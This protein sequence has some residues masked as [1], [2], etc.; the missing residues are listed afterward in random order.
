MTNAEAAGKLSLLAD[1]LEIQGEPFYKVAAY[2]R[3]ADAVTGLSESLAAVRERGGLTQIPGVGPAI[4]KKLESL[5]DTGT[6]DLLEKVTQRVPPTLAELLTVP[7]IGPKR[8]RLL[9]EELGI[10]SLDALRAAVESGRLTTVSGIGPKGA[11]RIAESLALVQVEE[12]R[13]QLGRAW[14]A[15]GELIDALTAA[16]P[17]L[18][19][20]ALAGSARRARETVGDLDLVAAHPEPRRVVDAFGAM[21][22]VR[23]V[24]MK[25]EN[26]CRVLQHNGLAADLRVLPPEHWGSLLHHFTGSKYH[27]VKLRDV[28]LQ[29][30]IHMNEYGFDTPNGLVPCASEEDVYRFLDMQYVPPEMREDTGEIELAMRGALPDWL[31]LEQIR[32]DFQMHTTWSDGTRTVE[33]M[34]AAARAQ[35]YDY[36]LVTDHS[37]SLGVANGLSPERLRA[38]RREI[39]AAN[40]KLAPF[41]LLQAVE[42]EVKSNGEMDLPDEVLAELDVVVAS[43]H[44]GL[45][46]GRPR[47]TERALAAIRHPLVDI[48]AHPTGRLVGG[49][50]GGDFDME[51]II[52]AAADTGTALEINADP[53]R[54]DLRDVHARAAA[55][56][57]CTIAISSDAHSAEGLGNMRFG[58]ATAVRAWVPPAQVLNTYPLDQMLSRL[59]RRRA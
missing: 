34:G 42:L 17:D 24:E 11:R 31:R 23:R 29:R 40:E 41:R 18:V 7:D 3:A 1:L 56:A 46:Q 28:V 26:R 13:M 54:L 10:E 48:I 55:S 37:Q 50:A 25:G 2:R 58:A 14:E 12:Q 6:F 47:L 19:A 5:L 38:Q 57:G 9:H 22:S 15:G 49:R 35:G 52:Q 30:G 8:A 36:I 59:K 16:C 32:G 53:A 33:E 27:N 39:D 45:R 43:V 21:P 51:A 4:E 44:T 20:A